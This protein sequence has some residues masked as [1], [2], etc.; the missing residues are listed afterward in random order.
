MVTVKQRLNLTSLTPL[1]QGSNVTTNVGLLLHGDN[2]GRMPF[3]LASK[4]VFI[5]G[6]DVNNVSQSDRLQETWQVFETG[7]KIATV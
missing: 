3:L 5:V 4:T 2:F 7:R 6:V 1:F